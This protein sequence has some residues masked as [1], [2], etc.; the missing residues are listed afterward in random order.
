MKIIM[1]KTISKKIYQR[2]K[3]TSPNETKGALF[4]KKINDDLYEIDAVYFEKIIGTYAFVKLYNNEAYK[5]FQ[6]KY[7][8]KHLNDYE[9]H[10]Y[11]GDWHSHPSFE[12]YPSS[13][14]RLEV[15]S[16]LQKSNAKFLIQMI[17]KNI[18]QSL[19]GNCFL[20]NAFVS[21]EQIELEIQM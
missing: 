13:Y 18:N 9:T 8:A 5:K 20:Y 17:L 3:E 12:C 6:E 1:P 7:H 21:V 11:I 14:D 10:N 16:D 2:I 4:A 15:E 19:T